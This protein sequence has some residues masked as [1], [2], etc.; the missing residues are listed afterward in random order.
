MKCFPDFLKLT[1][2]LL[3]CTGCNFDSEDDASNNR[4]ITSNYAVAGLDV[5]SFDLNQLSQV[6][7]MTELSLAKGFTDD[8]GNATLLVFS[9][10]SEKASEFITGT[11]SNSELIVAGVSMGPVTFSP[12]VANDVLDNSAVDLSGQYRVLLA[13]DQEGQFTIEASG[14]IR[15]DNSFNGCQLNGE[16]RDSD[17]H[18][19]LTV[20]ILISDCEGLAGSYAGLSFSDSDDAPAVAHWVLKN[21]DLALVDLLIYPVW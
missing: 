14:A 18:G 4:G 16:V 11:F 1:A 12:A 19:A 9:H 5:G 13:D 8:E 10:N 7:G 2:M 21:A 15:T 3:A 6:N 20:E 17:L